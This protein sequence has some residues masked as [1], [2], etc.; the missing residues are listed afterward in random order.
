M[1]EIRYN[2]SGLYNNF[3]F[4]HKRIIDKSSDLFPIAER[5]RLFLAIVTQNEKEDY[6]YNN[7]GLKIYYVLQPNYMFHSKFIVEKAGCKLMT[8]QMIAFDNSYQKFSSTPA[9]HSPN[10]RNSYFE[11]NK[12]IN[13]LLDLCDRILAARTKCQT[14]SF[15][16]YKF[17]SSSDSIYTWVTRHKYTVETYHHDVVSRSSS[18]GHKIFRIA[19]ASCE[20]PNYYQQ[21]SSEAGAFFH[22]SLAASPE[23]F[24]DGTVQWL[25]YII[26]IKDH[27]VEK[28]T[29]GPQTI[30]QND[31][32][33]I[34]WANILTTP[35]ILLRL[36]LM[37]RPPRTF[38]QFK[39]EIEKAKGNLHKT[40]PRLVS[41]TDNAFSKDARLSHYTE[42]NAYTI[43][44]M[45][46]VELCNK[47]K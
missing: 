45:H 41:L 33:H 22:Y 47:I 11:H 8:H 35:F 3:V 26:H 32:R 2:S 10:I 36:I 29:L 28:V 6:P 9:V 27:L 1:F 38:K 18:T 19:H 24:K 25:N 7:L 42:I 15:T 5:L 17:S 21:Q 30:Y 13:N 31:G 20:I 43:L 46:F 23:D 40:S 44:K 37:G 4:W 39:S 34:V 12:Y 14:F 16:T